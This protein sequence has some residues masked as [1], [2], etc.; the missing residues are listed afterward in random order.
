MKVLKLHQF[1]RVEKGPVNSLIIDFLQGHV[2]HVSNDSLDFFDKGEY[3]KVPDLVQ[4]LSEDKLVIEIEEDRWIPYYDFEILP[5]DKKD[6]RTGIDIYTLEIDKNLDLKIVSPM[7]E[8]Y[9]VA[10]IFY[11]DEVLPD[12]FF[13]GVKR[14]KKSYDFNGCKLLSQINE[15]FQVITV[16][17]YEFN[18]QFNSCWGGKVAICSDLTLR[19]CIYSNII[20]GNLREFRDPSDLKEKLKPY[21]GLTKD[22]V[23]RCKDCEFR[24]ICFDCREI[25]YRKTHHLDSENFQCNYDPQAGKWK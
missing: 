14:E 23:I 7:L 6:D 21:W 9:R 22:K 15:E 4:V 1:V 12:S 16:N 13:P 24:Y 10:R 20:I 18:I 2:F 11:Y 5:E 17:E 19:P 25:P 8:N 3:D